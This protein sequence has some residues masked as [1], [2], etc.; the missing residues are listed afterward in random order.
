MLRFASVSAVLCSGWLFLGWACGAAAEVGLRTLNFPDPARGGVGWMVVW[1]PTTEPERPVRR[2]PFTFMAAD[3]AP[4]AAGRHPLV[5][6]SHGS[7]GSALAHGDTA[8]ALAR[9]GYVVAAVHHGGNAFDDDGDA[10]TERMWKHR[11]VQFSAA[12]DAVLADPELG[13]RV[14]AERIGALGMS[15]GGFTVL[16]AAGAV[17]DLGHI[18]AYCATQREDPGFCRGGGPRWRDVIDAHDRRLRAV[19]AM[20][21]V[22]A[23]FGEDAF[24]RVTVPVRLYRAELDEL[25][26]AAQLEG[27]RDRLPRPP[28][29]AVVEGAGHYAFL[30][31][32]PASVLDEVGA[33]AQDP[34]GFDRVAFHERL[35]REVVDFFDRALAFAG[36]GR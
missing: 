34:P 24:A 14:D 20:A 2:G 23:M 4:V 36:Q 35:N 9:R 1:Y 18:A 26:G 13:G 10:G 33:P 21:P 28:E 32:F 22:A 19:V 31:P 3:G 6:V 17:A 8:E 12:L 15:A 27:V 11:P 7:G 5:V 16:A 25:V 30:M 29:Y